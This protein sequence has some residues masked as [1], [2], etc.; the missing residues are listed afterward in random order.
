M[1]G[2]VGAILGS[3]VSEKTGK[4]QETAKVMFGLAVI[5]GIAM[6]QCLGFSDMKVA[7][8]ISSAL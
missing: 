8:V 5:S 2:V 6:D 3:V 4:M 7:L 1:T